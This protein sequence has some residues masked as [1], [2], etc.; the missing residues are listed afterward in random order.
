MPVILFTLPEQL[1]WLPIVCLALGFVCIIL[2]MNL[3]GFGFPGITGIILLLAGI[4]LLA[5]TVLEAIIMVVALLVLV[6]VLMAI[7]LRS[8]SSGRL[9]K[10]VILKDSLKREFGFSSTVNLERFLNKEGTTL[11][12]L[13]P[14]GIAEI[15]GEKLDVVTQGEFIQVGVKVK[16]IKVEGRRIVVEKC[17]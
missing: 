1:S 12:I 17:D 14:A 5:D 3:P 10:T 13:R 11:T 4:I 7:I 6:G 8:A 16:V 2:E 15:E 9:S